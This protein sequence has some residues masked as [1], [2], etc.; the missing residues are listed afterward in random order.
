MG[1]SPSSSVFTRERVAY[2]CSALLISALVIQVFSTV[3]QGEI[4]GDFRVFYAEGLHLNILP[5]L[6]LDA[7][8]RA[9]PR[10]TGRLMTCSREKE[11]RRP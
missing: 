11:S 10:D 5:L 2:Y 1:F 7:I 9:A 4:G 6:R 8:I 3:R